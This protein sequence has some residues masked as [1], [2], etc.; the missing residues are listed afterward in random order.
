MKEFTTNKIQNNNEIIAQEIKEKRKDLKLDLNKVSQKTKINIKYL[1]ALENGQLNKLPAGVYG[2]KILQEYSNFLKLDTDF[3]LEV[4]DLETENRKKVNQ[5]N[6]FSYKVPHLSYFLTIPKI[7]KNLIILLAVLIC[8]TY[9]GYYIKNIIEAPS[10]IITSPVDNMKTKENF[11]NIRGKTESEA[12]VTINNQE[13]LLDPQG[14]FVKKVNLSNGLNTISI[15]AQKKYSKKNIVK[16][17]I[18]VD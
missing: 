3:L 6:I 1:K 4:W 11:I 7:I 15:I 10:L 13:V 14:N 17:R 5:K 18:L 12:N 8:L 2:K 16:K 9:L